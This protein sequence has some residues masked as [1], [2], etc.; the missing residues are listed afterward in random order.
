MATALELGRNG[1]KPYLEASR[2]QIISP[3]LTTAK[4]KERNYLLKGI[5][6]AAGK[7]KKDFGTRKVILFGSLARESWFTADSDVD[8]AVEGL[9]PDDYWPAWRMIETII[10][11]RKV[12][13]IEIERVGESL[14]EVIESDGVEL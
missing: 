14:R 12:D 4:R 6:K 11:D 8:L 13:L 7:L 9:S 1:W 10:Q 3:K 2:P 5:R